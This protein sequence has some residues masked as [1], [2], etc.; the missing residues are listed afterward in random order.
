[1]SRLPGLSALASEQ[2]VIEPLPAPG[3]SHRLIGMR[4]DGRGSMAVTAEHTTSG[5]IAYA[6][7]ISCVQ[8][9]PV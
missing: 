1:M 7:R 8:S 5:L 6:A 3:W 4:S 9:M 2:P